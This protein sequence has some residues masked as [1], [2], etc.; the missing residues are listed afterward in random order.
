MTLFSALI[1][2]IRGILF[3]GLAEQN[4]RIERKLQL[5][6]EKIMVSKA[7][8]LAAIE[9][10]KAVAADEKEEVLA[11]I[12]AAVTAAVSPL[13]Q[14]ILELQAQIANGVDLT[15]VLSAVESVKADVEA[16]VTEV[17]PTPEPDEPTE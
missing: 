9:E 8:V 15:D 14:V 17:E 1:E 10:L 16:I 13:E 11:A 4:R 6:E 12:A 2:Q 7:D 3:G 5:L